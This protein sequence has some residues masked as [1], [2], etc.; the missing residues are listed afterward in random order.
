MKCSLILVLS[1]MLTPLFAQT[2]STRLPLNDITH[3]SLANEERPLA[4]PPIREADILWEKRVWRVIDTREKMNLPFR[5]PKQ[6]FI[7]LLTEAVE[8]GRLQAFGT[9][10][11]EFSLPLSQQEVTGMLYRTDTIPVHDFDTGQE[12]YQVV[13]D[14]LNPGDIKRFR[15]KEHWFFDTRTSTLQVRILGI[16]PLLEEYDDNGEFKYER[17]LFWIYYP[18]A[19]ELLSHVNAPVD[20]LAHSPMSWADL[21]DMRRFSSYI[22]KASNI[23]DQRLEAT[24]TGV[25]LLQ[26]SQRLEQEIFNFEHDLWSY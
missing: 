11:D 16:A 3:R 1:I 25:D 6:P 15:I 18:D 4:F 14:D 5:Y 7:T 10:N 8:S 2:E 23:H 22:T 21:L 19:R 9:E 26:Q 17:P 24:Y 20:G 13:R 12:V